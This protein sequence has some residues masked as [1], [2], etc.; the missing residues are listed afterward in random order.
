MS[1]IPKTQIFVIVS[2]SVCRP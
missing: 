1:F 2:L